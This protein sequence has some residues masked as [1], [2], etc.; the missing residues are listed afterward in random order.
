MLYGDWGT[1]RLYVLGLA[2]ALAGHGSIYYIVAVS[3][4]MV[5]VGWAYTHICRIF[6]DGGGVYSAAKQTSQLLAVVGAL[7]LIAGYVITASLSALCAFRYLGVHGDWAWL[8]TIGV[9]VL[10]GVLNAYGPRRVGN[11]ALLIAVIT[12]I[13]FLAIAVFTVPYLSKATFAVPQGGPL[14]NWLNFVGVILAL[15]GVESVAN[16][17]GIMNKPVERTSAL[18]IWPVLLEVAVINIVLGVAM[19]A[20]DPARLQKLGLHDLEKHT[21]YMVKVLAHYYTNSA[22]FATICSGV[23]ALLLFSAANTAVGASV[24]VLFLLGRD[25]ELPKPLTSL[26]RYGVPWVALALATAVPILTLVFLKEVDKLAALYAIGVAGAIT[27][28][29]GS[30]TFTRNVA[31]TRAQRVLM[32]AVMVVMGTIALTL[33]IVERNA[34]IFALSVLGAGL[35]A[36]AG[37]KGWQR[38]RAAYPMPLPELVKEMIAPAEQAVAQRV[39]ISPEQPR[40]L[41]ALR[42]PGPTL[43]Y[44]FEETQRRNAALFV[45]FVRE[46]AVPFPDRERTRLR[47]EDDKEAQ[48]LFQKVKE[49]AKEK[50]VPVIPI[51]DSGISAADAILDHA[52]TLGVDCLIMGVSKRGALWRAMKGDVLQDV[53]GIL[54]EQIT[55]LIHA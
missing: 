37:V 38:F 16:M 39:I 29:V 27:I 48:A 31:L 22:A 42:G 24:S 2:F 8:W 9:L 51:Y 47:L 50:E 32:G 23:F 19:C 41:V 6:P 36:R 14:K 52:V 13:L 3:V 7:L 45:L 10:I 40:L 34:L 21:D 15:S 17:T 44:A 30:C 28:N 35:G 1:S 54:P 49:L 43:N 12:V 11:L 53:M 25:D 18:S 20:M 4:L 5:F 46:L 55:L 26:N 33:A